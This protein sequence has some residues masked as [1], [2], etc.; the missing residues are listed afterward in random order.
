[1]YVYMYVCIYI[2]MCA[3]GG[4]RTISAVIP[5]SIVYHVLFFLAESLT[6]LTL[7]K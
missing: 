3:Y 4:Q 1:M 2:F 5:Q 6:D 7:T